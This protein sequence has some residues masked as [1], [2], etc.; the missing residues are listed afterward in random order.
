MAAKTPD[1]VVPFSAGNMRGIIATF[2]TANID[3]NDTWTSGFKGALHWD[4]Q[5]SIDGPQDC[6][7]DSYTA[8]TGEFRF[9]SVANATGRLVVWGRGY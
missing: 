6:T 3:D 8:A 7:V 4:F 9:G 1:S 2:E 5:N